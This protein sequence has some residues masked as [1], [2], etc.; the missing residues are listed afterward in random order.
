VCHQSMSDGG[1]FLARID[2]RIKV[3]RGDSRILQQISMTLLSSR[4]GDERGRRDY[5]HMRISMRIR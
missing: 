2:R 4:N 3:A 5:K 1:R